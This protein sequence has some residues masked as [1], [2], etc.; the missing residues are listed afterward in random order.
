MLVLTIFTNVKLL[1]SITRQFQSRS[2]SWGTWQW[3]HPETK[4]GTA[5]LERSDGGLSFWAFLYFNKK[6]VFPRSPSL[7]GGSSRLAHVVISKLILGMGMQLSRFTLCVLFNV[8]VTSHMKH[9]LFVF[10][11]LLFNKCLSLFYCA[12]ILPACMHMHV[13]SVHR[14]QK[15]VLDPQELEWQILM[16]CLP[17]RCWE[18]NLGP[19]HNKYSCLPSSVSPAWNFHFKWSEIKLSVAE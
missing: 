10:W 5:E 3:A 4:E 9:F 17:Y 1:L 12:D 19:L 16:G 2:L 6:R 13:C 8:R 14:D 18:L 7:T 15:R 11:R